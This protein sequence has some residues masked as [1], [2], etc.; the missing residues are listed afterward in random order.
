MFKFMFQFHW[1]SFTFWI[2]LT[3]KG[4]NFIPNIKI[5]QKY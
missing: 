5:E 2:K 3:F 1:K 4:N